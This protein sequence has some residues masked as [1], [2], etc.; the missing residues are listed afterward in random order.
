MNW[1][2]DGSTTRNRCS[3]NLQSVRRIKT[4]GVGG[5]IHRAIELIGLSWEI[6]DMDCA[7]VGKGNVLESRRVSYDAV[8]E[9]CVEDGFRTKTVP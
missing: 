5:S 1:N 2:S 8:I 6:R 3:V 4:G 7:I 9:G